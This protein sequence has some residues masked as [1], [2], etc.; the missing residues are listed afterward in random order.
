MR[1]YTQERN[2][3]IREIFRSMPRKEQMVL[4]RMMDT[5]DGPGMGII[6]FLDMVISLWM[7]KKTRGALIKG[8]FGRDT[9][10]GEHND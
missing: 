10:R 7:D 1:T 4:E 8:E 6:T 2:K 5:F 3:K 9:K